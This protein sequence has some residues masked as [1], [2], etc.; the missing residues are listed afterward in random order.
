MPL[1]GRTRGAVSAGVALLGPDSVGPPC[2]WGSEPARARP[3]SGCP[4]RRKLGCSASPGGAVPPSAQPRSPTSPGALPQS[5]GSGRPRR[6]DAR[7]P[8]ARRGRALGWKWDSVSS[9]KA[10][11]GELFGRLSSFGG[12]RPRAPEAAQPRGR[13]NGGWQTR[14][15]SA[16]GIRM[17]GIVTAAGAAETQV[18]FFRPTG[19]RDGRSL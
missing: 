18:H 16:L 15:E 2:P 5:R 19:L 6:E 8:S 14:N 17:A 1:R 10:G 3:H 11:L 13:T 12:A 9:G 7:R 4:R